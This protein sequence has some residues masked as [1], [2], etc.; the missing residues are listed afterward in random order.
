MSI[1]D[2]SGGGLWTADQG[3]I[4]CKDSWKLFD[5]N[6]EHAT[7]PFK[8]ERISFIAFAH[9]QYN[10]LEAPVVKMLKGMGF[11]AARSDGVCIYGR[12]AYR[13][14]DWG[15]CVYKMGKITSVTAARTPRRSGR[16]P[17]A[18]TPSGTVR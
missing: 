8:G 4:D 6:K 17:T 2:H 9:G 12:G 7:R 13:R 5:G 15:D 18:P 3:V 16:D 11:N 1:G 10:K 14:L